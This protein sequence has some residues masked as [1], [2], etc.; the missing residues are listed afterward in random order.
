MAVPQAGLRYAGGY[1]KMGMDS[2]SWAIFSIA[3]LTALFAIHKAFLKYFRLKM[4]FTILINSRR[5]S[6]GKLY[7]LISGGIYE[8]YENAWLWE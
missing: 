8:V 7:M 1:G 2:L 4:L 3:L 6:L 5:N